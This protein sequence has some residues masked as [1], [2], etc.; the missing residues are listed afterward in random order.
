M[1]QFQDLKIQWN[2]S[3][4]TLPKFRLSFI[5]MVGLLLNIIYSCRLGRWE[6]LLEFIREVIAYAFAYDHVNYARYLTVMLG[7]M[8][9]LEEQFPEV[10]HQCIPGNFAAELSDRVFS[11]VE[12]DKIIEMTKIKVQKHLVETLVFQQMLVL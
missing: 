9:S 12:T 6:L 5:D 1:N 2:K 10:Y 7:E 3:C 4:F 11:R 8:F